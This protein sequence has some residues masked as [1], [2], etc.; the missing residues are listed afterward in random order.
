[1][2]PIGTGLLVSS[3]TPWSS[4]HIFNNL[5]RVWLVTSFCCQ[6]DV[7]GDENESKIMQYIPLCITKTFIW[8]NWPLDVKYFQ[9]NIL[10][11]IKL[12]TGKPAQSNILLN[13]ILSFIGHS[14]KW[15]TG[16]CIYIQASPTLT[17]HMSL[18][19]IHP[20][21]DVLDLWITQDL[22]KVI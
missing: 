11:H 19:S 13:K 6:W 10:T 22:F 3:S 15:V 4:P 7:R 18:K 9:H 14:R 2:K 5:P 17:D 20:H 16:C 8:T 12:Q 21:L 1:M